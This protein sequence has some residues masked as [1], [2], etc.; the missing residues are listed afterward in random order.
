MNT[1]LTSLGEIEDYA[2][3]TSGQHAIKL[4]VVDTT[5]KSTV[6]SVVID[7][8]GPN[9]EPECE[10]TLPQSGDAYII[11]QNVEFQGVATDEDINNSLLNITWESDIDGIFNSFAAAFR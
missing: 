4:T 9:N 3:L 7:V 6:E 2:T 1:T 10:I 11:G 5:G 8:A